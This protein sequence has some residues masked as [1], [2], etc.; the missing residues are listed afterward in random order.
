MVHGTVQGLQN[1]EQKAKN[2]RQR[3]S[4]Q[5]A[6][7]AGMLGEGTTGKRC[8]H[9]AA[10]RQVRVRVSTAMPMPKELQAKNMLL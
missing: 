4:F 7:A 2:S 6:G 5:K 1:N 3:L 9:H 8:R 10:R